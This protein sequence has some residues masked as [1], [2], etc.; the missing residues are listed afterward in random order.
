MRCYPRS[1]ISLRPVAPSALEQ[2]VVEDRLVVVLA[3][4]RDELVPGHTCAASVAAADGCDEFA[5]LL[6][7]AG[8]DE[9]H[10]RLLFPD[11]MTA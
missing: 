9:L 3:S 10:Q 11:K 4:D 8:C 5:C 6:A 2:R 7:V 1:A